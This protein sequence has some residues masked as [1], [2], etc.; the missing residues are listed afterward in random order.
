MTET[1]YLSENAKLN[2]F[3]ENKKLQL[4]SDKYALKRYF[5]DHV[6]QNTVFFHNLEE[7]LKYLRNEQYYDEK[8]LDQYSPAFIKQVF[9]K[10]YS[11]K[12][13]FKAFLGAYKFYTHYAL[14]SFDGSRY[15][16]RYEDRIAMVAL[17]LGTKMTKQQV[18]DLVD[19]LMTQQFMVATPT[20]L[21]AG[22]KQAG[23]LVSCF[24]L[25][26]EDSMDSICDV[27]A[28]CLQLSKIG[29]GVSVLMT[30]IREQSAPIKH[31]QNQSS[32]VIPIMKILEDCFSYANQ[33]GARQGAGAVYLHAHHPDIIQF[34][35]TKRENADEKVRIKSLSI[36]VVV[37]DIT[38]ELAKNNDDM[39]LFSPYDILAH[40][41]TAMADMNISQ[42]YNQL[43]QTSQIRKKKIK[44]RDFFQN[45]AQV[46]FESGYPYI[47]FEDNVNKFN[48]IPNQRINMSNL[49]TEILQDNQAKSDT[50]PGR[51]ISCNLGSMNIFAA[52]N[53]T[54]IDKTVDIAIRTLTAVSEISNI[55]KVPSI[56]HNNS[57]N[58]AIGLGQ[59]NLHGFL[60]SENIHYG[61][62]EAIEFTD[63]YFKLIRYHAIK[64]SNQ[65]AI[66]KNQTFHDFDNSIYK[67]K[68]WVANYIDSPCKP[69]IS[70]V[71]AIFDKRGIHLPEKEDW[72]S[73]ANSVANRGIYNKYLLAVAPTGSISYINNSTSSIHPIASKIEIRKE[74]KIGRVYY[75]QPHMTNDNLDYYQDSYEL[76]FAK[77]IDTYAAATPHVDQGLSL[78]LFFPDTATTRDINKAQIYAWQKGIKTLYYCRIKQE[79][80]K[81]TEI[82]SCVSCTL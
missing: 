65:I 16:E 15:F 47:M 28:A 69:Q 17:S 11:H 48:V 50:S 26:T 76:G 67:D 78:T 27:I 64:T 36:G 82:D 58:R 41:G 38:F 12:F 80:L 34:I 22:K 23:E 70:P 25:R 31:H 49:C 32:G 62:P 10:A 14:K 44:A 51:D 66:E 7:K 54:N 75:P 61:S 74:G 57:I 9:Q 72:L 20:L 1:L 4:Q 40:T 55:S 77:I 29:G 59:M 8:V 24:L 79:A 35:D 13:R 56:A 37:P 45:I 68:S 6:N 21:N 42:N 73:L 33:L 63:F 43:L 53:N 46:Q 81:G 5:L 19:V 18:L 2:L 60:A 39:Y 3:D 30:N 71:R 52:I